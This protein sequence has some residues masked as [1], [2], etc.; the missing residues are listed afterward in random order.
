MAKMYYE[1]DADLKLLAG[2]TVAVLGLR[3]KVMRR[4]RILTT[5]G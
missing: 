1:E 5:A 2:K 3:A 4:L